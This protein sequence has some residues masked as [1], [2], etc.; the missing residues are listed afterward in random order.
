MTLLGLTTDPLFSIGVFFLCWHT[1][2]EMPHA[3]SDI[4]EST[5]TREAAHHE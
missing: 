5:S 1:W 4:T 2:Q 3:A